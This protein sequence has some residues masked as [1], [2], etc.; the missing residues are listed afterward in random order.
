MVAYLQKTQS[1][2]ESARAI[3]LGAFFGPSLVE[4]EDGKSGLAGY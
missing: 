2:L 3:A 1:A 4:K